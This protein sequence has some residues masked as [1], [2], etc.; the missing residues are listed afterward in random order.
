M[1]RITN[2]VAASHQFPHNDIIID[3]GIATTFDILSFE[4]IYLGRII[5]ASICLAMKVLN[6]N[7]AKLP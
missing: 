7:T 5:T 6:E 3:L 4:R 2:F 1:N